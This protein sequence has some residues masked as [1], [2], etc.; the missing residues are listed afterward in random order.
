MVFK[1]TAV[2]VVITRAIA[3]SSSLN[4]IILVALSE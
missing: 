3:S 4:F 1:I 2:F